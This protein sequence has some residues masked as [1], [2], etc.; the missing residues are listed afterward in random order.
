[1][2]ALKVVP[3]GGPRPK[4]TRVIP[5]AIPASAGRPVTHWKEPE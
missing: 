5:T 1:M 2:L 4:P 3:G